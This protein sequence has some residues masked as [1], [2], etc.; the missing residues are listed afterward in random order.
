MSGQERELSTERGRRSHS[1]LWQYVQRGLVYPSP[2]ATFVT[3]FRG[4]ARRPITR[5]V[6]GDI[7]RRAR[8]KI[9]DDFGKRHTTAVLGLGFATWR[10]ICA[11]EGLSIP[12][13]M[14]PKF[15]SD[16]D[17]DRS[18]V[19][20]RKGS[21]FVDSGADLW[22][23]LKSDEA[24]HLEGLCA[25]L[26]ALVE[27]ELAIA[28]GARTVTQ[29]AATK[30]NADDHRGGKVLGARF[31]EN[32]NNATDP[33]T[34]QRHTIV[35]HDDL[36]HLGA[37]YVLAQ[38]FKINWE[39]VLSMSPQQVEDMVGRSSEDDRIIPSRDDRSHIKRARAQDHAGNTT[40]VLRLGLPFGRSGATDNPTL[41][42]R[43]ASRR[44]E[45]GIYFAGYAASAQAL[46][47]IMDQQIGDVP[48]F[49]ADRLLA[50][51]RSD[52]GGFYYIPSLPDLGLEP[53]VGGASYKRFP[54]VDW[55]RL[56]RHFDQKP[57]DNEYLHYNH[58]QYLFRMATMTEADREAYSPPSHRVLELL[59]DAFSRW[60][61][62]WYFDRTPPEFEHLRAY[63]T[64]AYGENEAQQIMALSIEE[65]SGWATKVLLGQVLVSDAYGYRGRR[66][67]KNGA[68]INGADTY[69]IHP[70]EI[71]V[72]AMPNLGLGQGKYMIDFARD[73][74]RLENFFDN[75]SYASGVGHVVPTFD[76]ALE[77]GLPGLV[78]K[79]TRLRDQSSND[80]KKRRFFAGALLATEGVVEHCLAYAKLADT[81]ASVMPD[82]QRAEQRNL[83]EIAERMRRLTLEPPATL[84]DAA[85]LVFTLHSCLHH[86]GEPTA[87]GRL[88]QLLQPFYR[89]DVDAG[90]IDGAQAQE[91]IDCFWLKLGEK[92]LLNRQ[93]VDDHQV[94][95]NLAMGGSSGNYP[96]GSSLNQWIQQVTV[97]GT[98]ADDAPGAGRPAY[99][100][101]TLLCLRAARRLPLNAPCLSLRMREDVPDEVVREAAKAILSG[102]AHPILLSDDK[103]IPGLVASGD[104]IGDGSTPTKSTP[105]REKAGDRWRSAV[106]LRDARDYAC[107]GC[108]EPQ[109]S[110]TSWFTLGG[111]TATQ[112]LEAALNQGK[113]WQLAGPVWFRG[114]KVSF[115]SEP[116]ADIASF[117]RLIEL[118][119]EHMRWM[120]AKQVDGQLA[121][122]GRMN[123]VC[124]APLLSVFIDDCLDKG[125]DYYEG[126]PR[127]NVVAPCFTG[128]STLI[129]SL[130]AIRALVFDPSTA[131]TSLPELVDALRCDWGERMVEPFAS[132]LEGSA[133]IEA[134]ASRFRQIRAAAM[135]LPRFGRGHEPIDTFGDAIVAKIAAV[136]V[137]VF[138]QPAERTAARMV[139]LAERL[140]TPERPFGGFQIQPGVGSFENYLDWGNMTG[141]SADGRRSGDPFASDLSPS[142]SFG[143][144]A[145][146]H[147]EASIFETLKGYS[148]KGVEAMWDGAPTD[149]NIRENFPQPVLE[150]VLVEF[151]KGVGSSILTITCADADTLERATK[152]PEKYDVV[153]VRMG[154]WSEFFVTMF[155]AHQAQHQRRPICTP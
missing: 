116:A 143:D 41:L 127:Y 86:A 8:N 20:E 33:I 60:Q 32:L 38:R 137:G 2:Y 107:D 29:D 9:H 11:E 122:F 58:K 92:A 125:L 47:T 77:I 102:G 12:H 42:Q 15:P 7:Y 128:L 40:P 23:H 45:E 61:D 95:G 93:F 110:G 78:E 75:L 150:R 104:R 54:G 98:I 49:M 13:A 88:D 132:T 52:L 151:A 141:A 76:E 126:G 35:G 53:A 25:Y 5:A 114:Q 82:G 123:A 101:V 113:A 117:D 84:A 46:E 57:D 6:L 3:F 115:T 28:D 26:R 59:A 119:L 10:R 70:K 27:E 81:I 94:F 90:R 130:W 83:Q 138:T 72:G 39:Q 155:P 134:R 22:F 121:L 48:G 1:E 112:P 17:P 4:D 34:V 18:S 100:D 144:L 131:V 30:S 99:N 56:D 139:E 91:I 142:P 31:S 51:V 153:R 64:R 62:G 96:Q 80:E 36:S 44:D 37:S 118:Y 71:L 66:K 67:A 63:L 79:L 148:G 55:S 65:R 111:M 146:D 145:I 124:P 43:G 21:V 14:T 19:F 140:G 89:R 50:N 73:D 109:L 129:D 69:R 149:L 136:A 85:Q 103:I 74:E 152:D 108:Y 147:R 87:V 120:Y 135:A 97:G 105:V 24:S 16:A 154:G 133:R 106:S 68:M